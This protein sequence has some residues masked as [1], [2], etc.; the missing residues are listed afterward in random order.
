MS[1]KQP[2]LLKYSQN[3]PKHWMFKNNPILP[4][5]LL[6]N[7]CKINWNCVLLLKPIFKFQGCAC[8]F[9]YGPGTDEDKKEEL[10]KVENQQTYHTVVVRSPWWNCTLIFLIGLLRL[11]GPGGQRWAADG[12][13]ALQKEWWAAGFWFPP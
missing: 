10:E 12:S 9:L 11:T 13:S 5:M 1:P 4:T 6:L 7:S 8:K 2:F 3:I